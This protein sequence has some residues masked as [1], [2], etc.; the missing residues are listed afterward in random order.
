MNPK[1]TPT[2][3]TGGIPAEKT[4]VFGKLLSEAREQEAQTQRPQRALRPGWDVLVADSKKT[5]LRALKMAAPIL[6]AELEEESR[7][8]NGGRDYVVD[9]ITAEIK[10]TRALIASIEANLR[11]ES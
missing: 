4:Q 7:G 1:I 3:P 2:S 11:G 8:T 10:R 6:D 5:I 9:A